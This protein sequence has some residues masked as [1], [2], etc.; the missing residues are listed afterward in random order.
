MDDFEETLG[1]NLD[2]RCQRLGLTIDV[3]V[4]HHSTRYV[5]HTAWRISFQGNRSETCRLSWFAAQY[6]CRAIG[7]GKF[8]WI[9]GTHC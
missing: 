8:L 1:H 9:Q 6:L 2:I 4:D 3:D 5:L 7:R